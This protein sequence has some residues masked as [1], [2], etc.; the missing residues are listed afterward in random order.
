[1]DPEVK[2]LTESRECVCC[3]EDAQYALVT[4]G[5]SISMAWCVECIEGLA[6]IIV[7]V[8]A[9]MCSICRDRHPNDDRHPCE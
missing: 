6:A 2:L 7:G 1:M 3:G 5:G 4:A 8:V 9:P